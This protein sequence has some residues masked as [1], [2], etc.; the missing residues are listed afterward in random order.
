MKI[1]NAYPGSPNEPMTEEEVKNFMANN[2]NDLLI[3][4]GLIDEKGEPNVV[5][6]AYYFDEL[7]DKI[8]IN[9]LKTTKKVLGLRKNNIIAYCIDDPKFPFKGVRGK[10]TAII[11][12]DVNHNI[13]I[14]K[15]F[16]MKNIGSLDNPIAKWL[17]TEMENGN[18]VILEITPRYYST[19]RSAVPVK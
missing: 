19:W 2:D 18:E 12:E 10:A 17:L 15:K 3:R 1:I 13:P 7:S 9:T 14:A 5:P 8:Y 6:L 11:H 4:I 16:I